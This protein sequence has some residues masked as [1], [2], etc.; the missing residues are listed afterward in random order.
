MRI[1]S[2]AA[3]VL[4][5]LALVISLALSSL[6]FT[7]IVTGHS[8]GNSSLSVGDYIK[9]GSY[10]WKVLSVVDGR[11]LVIT[12][13]VIEDRLFDDDGNSWD[14]SSLRAYL[15]GRFYDQFSADE[16]AAIILTENENSPNSWTKAQSGSTTQDYV[17][18][19]SLPEVLEYF[20][21]SGKFSKGPNEDCRFSDEFDA[22]RSATHIGG[23]FTA[24]DGDVSTDKAG[25]VKCWWLRTTG[26]S[27]GRV[28][29]IDYYGDIWV[30]G[31]L[32]HL[33][34]IG[35]RPAMWIDIQYASNK[36]STPVEETFT[37]KKGDKGYDVVHIQAKL[38]ELGYLAGNA[39]GDF[40]K[41]TE[42]AVKRFQKAYGLE[43]TG[44]IT[45][46]EMA[47]LFSASANSEREQ[48]NP[49]PSITAAPTIT[50]LP[51]YS[52]NDSVEDDYAYIGNANSKKFHYSW[53]SSV[54]DMKEKNKVPF[55]S[56]DEAI[57]RGYKPCKR[58]N[59]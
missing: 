42:E 13:Q 7:E 56:R 59:P 16:R 9:F 26:K 31:Y 1:N 45:N 40:G 6:P 50:T 2:H 53:C 35:V 18:L 27:Q 38:I 28:S 21:D 41:K 3:R 5:V 57:N 20:G 52:Q 49:S 37:I 22:T 36:A 48:E 43:Q 29:C 30:A 4:F 47:L 23:T 12:N 8:E 14:Q 58:C 39:D 32:A 17:F 51:S 44:I 10:D 15:N 55:S 25:E 46:T 24:P 33:S 11:A 54:S 34:S 19:L